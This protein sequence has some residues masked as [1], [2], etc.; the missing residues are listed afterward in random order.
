MPDQIDLDKTLEELRKLLHEYSDLAINVATQH[1]LTE[2]IHQLHELKAKV[3]R[4]KYLVA[5]RQNNDETNHKNF[6]AH[7]ALALRHAVDHHFLMANH[8]ET[9]ETDTEIFEEEMRDLAEMYKQLWQLY[10]RLCLEQEMKQHLEQQVQI[11]KPTAY[12]SPFGS[13]RNEE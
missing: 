11:A 12:P 8:L 2:H 10:D 7:H 4:L 1:H 9:V 6:L 13:H 5:E 3:D